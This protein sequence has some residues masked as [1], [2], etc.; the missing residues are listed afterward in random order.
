MSAKPILSLYAALLSIALV[1]QG[2]ARAADFAPPSD[3]ESIHATVRF[4]DLDVDRPAGAAI[5]YHR[6]SAAAERVCGEPHPP[7]TRII[8]DAWRVCVAAA[9]EQAVKS[10]DRPAL[11]AYYDLHA[12]RIRQSASL[13][14]R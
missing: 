8:H 2:T 3:P 13:A 14:R 11:N 1:Y 6:I 9:V 12:G 4:G 10:V 7:G 5:L